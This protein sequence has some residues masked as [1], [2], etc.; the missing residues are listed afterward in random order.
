[1]PLRKTLTVFVV[2]YLLIL[3]L[4]SAGEFRLGSI[5]VISNGEDA[6]L[7]ATWWL[8]DHQ[9]Q[10][11]GTEPCCSPSPV[12]VWIDIYHFNGTSLSYVGRLGYA[13]D[14]PVAFV[15]SGSSSLPPNAWL[16]FNGTHLFWFMPGEKCVRTLGELHPGFGSVRLSPPDVYVIHRNGTF[17]V[18]RVTESS[19]FMV[20]EPAKE[21]VSYVPPRFSVS[22]SSQSLVVEGNGERYEIPIVELEEYYSRQDIEHLAAVPVAGGVLIYYV[23]GHHLD[24][25]STPIENPSEVPLLFY[26]GG[27][28]TVYTF[29]EPAHTWPSASWPGRVS[30]SYPQCSDGSEPSGDFTTAVWLAVAILGAA[31]LIR[32]L[33][34]K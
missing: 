3:P 34:R 6:F 18:Y 7:L 33:G 10:C 12:S 14:L 11:P 21:H 15:S 32:T 31:V 22:I 9:C 2:M 26:R 1:M 5:T 17:E 24:N 29:I 13:E 23:P 25:S 28:L 4:A 8:Y 20:N 19:F 27:S 30:F 16:V